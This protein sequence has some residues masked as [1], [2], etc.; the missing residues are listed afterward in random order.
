VA[1][2]DE[3]NGAPL[4]AKLQRHTHSGFYLTAR[5]MSK[6]FHNFPKHG[7]AGDQGVQYRS[8]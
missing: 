5:T 7:P 2:K 4:E 1:G 6:W 8:L 3:E